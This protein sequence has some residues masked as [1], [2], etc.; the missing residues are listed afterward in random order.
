MGTGVGPTLEGRGVGRDVPP[1]VAV[2]LTVGCAVGGT[3]G[4]AVGT[5]VGAGEGVGGGITVTLP[6]AKVAHAAAQARMKCDP[7]AAFAGMVTFRLARPVESVAALPSDPA[8][9]HR[10]STS[11]TGKPVAVTLTVAPA[12]PLDGDTTTRAAARTTGARASMRA[13]AIV[14]PRNRES[15]APGRQRP[16]KRPPKRPCD[17]TFP[18]TPF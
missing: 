1:G 4:T 11:P 5:G 2:G 9:S 18:R 3:V 16:P 12:S 14:G 10:N 8:A 7:G 17:L 15:A 6:S 13:V